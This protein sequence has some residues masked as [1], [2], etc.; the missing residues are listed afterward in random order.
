VIASETVSPE[1]IA[2]LD[3]Y[4]PSSV[5]QYVHPV[6]VSLESREVYHHTGMMLWGATY[7]QIMDG[8]V[9][10]YLLPE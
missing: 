1:M 7:R 4:N 2:F 6:L 3:S 10:K 8:F 5:R 9:R